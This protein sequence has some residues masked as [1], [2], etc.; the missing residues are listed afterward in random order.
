MTNP[1]A[2]LREREVAKLLCVSVRT[3]QRWRSSGDGPP[4]IRAGERLVIYDP[5]VLGVWAKA[6]TFVS[7]ATEIEGGDGRAILNRPL[8]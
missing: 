6:R 4:F 7:H 8:R 3:V 1:V 5:A 2:Y